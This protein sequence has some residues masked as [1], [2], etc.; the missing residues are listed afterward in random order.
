MV[1]VII[2]DIP[3]SKKEYDLLI[4]PLNPSSI[5]K[6]NRIKNK[7]ENTPHTKLRIVIKFGMCFLIF[8]E[9]R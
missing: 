1:A 5:E 3:T 9:Q 8:I 4:K 7:M 2:N 6:V